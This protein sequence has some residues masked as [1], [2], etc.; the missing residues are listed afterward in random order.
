VFYVNVP[1]GVTAMIVIAVMMV[2]PLEHRT[3]HRLDWAGI[4]TLLG[5]TVLLVFALESGAATMRGR[6]L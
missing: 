1:I 5:W 4:A 3:R 6:R 2:E